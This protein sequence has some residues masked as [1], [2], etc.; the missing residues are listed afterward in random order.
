[1][2]SQNL[3]NAP[4]PKKTWDFTSVGK[5]TWAF[6]S[7]SLIERVRFSNVPNS[8]NVKSK[9]K[10][11]PPPPKKK[12]E[13]LPVLLEVLRLL[14][15]GTHLKI[16]RILTWCAY[17][18]TFNFYSRFLWLSAKLSR[19]FQVN[20]YLFCESS[21]VIW[22]SNGVTINQKFLVRVLS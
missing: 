18:Y 12:H 15:Y 4:S 13:I 20:F 22:R 14:W 3:K 11:M 21:V 16:L 7:P 8:R 6:Y 5:G 1:M 17:F 10:K 2:S 19:Y 9:F